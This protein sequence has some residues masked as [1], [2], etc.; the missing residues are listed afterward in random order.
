M[1]H[2]FFVSSLYST[3]VGC[4]HVSDIFKKHLHIL[5][6]TA[7]RVVGYMSFQFLD[8]NDERTGKRQPHC[9]RSGPS[10]VL[11]NEVP[12]DASYLHLYVEAADHAS[13]S[14][15]PLGEDSA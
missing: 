2:E 5:P 4:G 1:N 13:S 3:K 11:V 6:L 15:R 14:D 10:A 12:E 9:L 8:C 7:A